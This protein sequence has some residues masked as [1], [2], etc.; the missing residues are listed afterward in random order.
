MR[1]CALAPRI[2]AALLLLATAVGPAAAEPARGGIFVDEL[3]AELPTT[4]SEAALQEAVVG[5]LILTVL[6]ELGHALISEL[7]LP[8]IGREEDVVDELAAY[9]L[10]AGSRE[11]AAGRLAHPPTLE[12][13]AGETLDQYAGPLEMRRE[14]ER[15]ALLLPLLNGAETW[16]LLH[17]LKDRGA[18]EKGQFPFW[19]EH[20]L[21]IQR[22]Y[23][24]L[25]LLYGSDPA[26]FW[27]V[28]AQSGIGVGRARKCEHEFE[29]KLKSW[30]RLL[31]PYLRP[32]GETPPPGRP[33]FN[34]T[35][36]KPER[37]S[38]LDWEARFRQ[39]RFWREL[40]VPIAD[41]IIL[42]HDID[43]RLTECG[44]W[45]A[46]WSPLERQLTICYEFLEGTREIHLIAAWQLH[47]QQQAAAQEGQQQGGGQ[48]QAPATGLDP[49]LLGTWVASL[50]HEGGGKSVEGAVFRPDGQFMSVMRHA[51]GTESRMVGTFATPK[52][53]VLAIEIA[54][55]SPADFRP[56]APS[57]AYR[58]DGDTLHASWV[59]TGELYRQ[60]DDGAQ[61]GQPGGAEGDAAAQQQP[62]APGASLLGHWAAHFTDKQDRKVKEFAAFRPDGTF[63][64]GWGLEGGEAGQQLEGTFRTPAPGRLEVAVTKASPEDYRPKASS[65][66]FSIQGE[67]LRIPWLLSGR[68]FRDTTS[69]EAAAATPPKTALDPQLFG[70]WAGRVLEGGGAATQI[71]VRFDPDGGFEMLRTDSRGASTRRWGRHV[72]SGAQLRLEIVGSEPPDTGPSQQVSPYEIIGNTLRTLDLMLYRQG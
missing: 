11:A 40:T 32:E 46:F 7:D 43:L 65:G 59:F 9:I 66:T 24:L 67:E 63:V 56:T 37:A 28:V 69:P 51:D 1:A 61:A 41:A 23:N 19:D 18:I 60:Q 38:S 14:Q 52:P 3:P 17:E 8:V 22:Y 35:Y 45:N 25:C 57:G 39:E 50:T 12:P 6:H 15:L 34:I 64:V 4:T 2:G 48:S 42:P 68:L 29:Q 36:V 55:S 31:G 16:R 70:L 44:M 20:G 49:K 33:G 13:Q 10:I 27:P 47:R 72:T 62:G 21:S 54:D 30:E 58:I 5:T 71:V 26:A 53:G